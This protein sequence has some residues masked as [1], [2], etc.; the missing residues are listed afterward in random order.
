M[1]ACMKM[2][3]GAANMDFFYLKL[4]RYCELYSACTLFPNYHP[5]TGVLGEPDFINFVFFC[6]LNVFSRAACC[7]L[8]HLEQNTSQLY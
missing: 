1:Y 8:S 7:Q 3:S 2:L 5:H 6:S 4:L